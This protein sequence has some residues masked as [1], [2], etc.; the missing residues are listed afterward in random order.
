[1]LNGAVRVDE[2][3]SHGH[4]PAGLVDERQV[5]GDFPPEI[6]LIVCDALRHQIKE[7]GSKTLNA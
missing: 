2:L 4:V 7:Q 5:E 3:P 1:M 6:H